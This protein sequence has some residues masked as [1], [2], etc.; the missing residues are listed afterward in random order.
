MRVGLRQACIDLSY[1]ADSPSCMLHFDTSFCYV[2]V[3]FAGTHV[4]SATR[5]CCPGGP[6]CLLCDG[7]TKTFEY[8][9]DLL[10]ASSWGST[11][12]NTITAPVSY[13]ARRLSGTVQQM[14]Q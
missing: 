8:C 2:H 13:V 1:T 12:W 10:Q 4:N 3:K 6:T 5:P 11:V 14:E 9:Y 7:I